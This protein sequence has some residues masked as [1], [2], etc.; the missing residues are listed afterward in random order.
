MRSCPSNPRTWTPAFGS[1]HTPRFPYEWLL[2]HDSKASAFTRL[3]FAMRPG[4][5]DDLSSWAVYGL[6]RWPILSPFR[7]RGPCS[8]CSM[9]LTCALFGSSSLAR[10]GAH[11]CSVARPFLGRWRDESAS[12]VH[13]RTHS[14]W[15]RNDPAGLRAAA[16][17]V[18]ENRRDDDPRVQKLQSELMRGSQERLNAAI[19][20]A[21]DRRPC[22]RL[23]KS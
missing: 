5:R 10:L 22:E 2:T 14:R 17:A 21:P 6:S 11:L 16:E 8:S 1:S 3:L 7:E 15:A 9:P 19:L 23:S 4:T 13:Q 20:L 12:L 18:A